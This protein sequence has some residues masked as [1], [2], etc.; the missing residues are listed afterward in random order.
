MNLSPKNPMGLQGIAFLEFAPTK[1]DSFVP[2]FEKLGFE[3]GATHP[4][5]PIT[6]FSQSEIHFFVNEFAEGFAAEFARKH[7]PSICGLGLKVQNAAE[8]F[9]CAILN[10]AEAASVVDYHSPSGEPLYA[11]YGIGGSVI[12]LVDDAI[13]AGHFKS[14]GFLERKKGS[15]P[16]PP[17]FLSIDH[18]T[19]NVPQGDL[20][21]WSSFYKDIFGFVEVRYFDITGNQTGLLSHALRSPCGTF[22][23]PINESKD[24]KS[25]IAEYLRE[26][27]GPGIQ[28]VAL[29]TDDLLSVLPDI[30]SALVPLLEIEPEYYQTVFERVPHVKEDPKAIEREGVLV[31]G[32]EQG[33][34][35]QIFSKKVIG[36]IFFE[37]IQRHNHHSFGE[38]NFQALFRTIERDQQLRGVL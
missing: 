24:E 32:D 16:T 13:A 19:N 3:V 21:H 23:I 35:L 26:Y 4:S 12:Y 36:P 18:L 1:K 5:L 34:L 28:H 37:F 31:D 27:H 6:I 2:L 11:I 15:S 14:L 25:Q 7:G 33:Y 29:L 30:R 9:E 17:K 20:E 22:C 38:G 10:G 8:A